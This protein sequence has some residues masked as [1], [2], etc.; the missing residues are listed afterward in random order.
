MERYFRTVRERFLDSDTPVAH[1]LEGLN[2][3]YFQWLGRYHDTVH[4]SLGITPLAR[5]LAGESV[6]R[7]IPESIDIEPLFRMSR[8][9]RVYLNSTIRLRKRSYEVPN[10]LPGQRV[11][12]WFLPWDLSVVWYG[13]EMQPTR[14]VDLHHNAITRRRQS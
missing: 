8:R 13:P 9:C 12:V 4:K 14:P 3:A 11:E 7:P 2:K 1:P 10:A 5:R 6:C